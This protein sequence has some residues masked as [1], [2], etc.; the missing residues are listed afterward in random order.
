MKTIT[1]KQQWGSTI[2]PLPDLVNKYIT[3]F[4]ALVLQTISPRAF[5]QSMLADL[6]A[7]DS[8]YI[9][10][11][12]YDVT[13]RVFGSH[14][15]TRHLIGQ[16]G[17]TQPIDYRPNSQ[18]NVGVGFNYNFFGLNLGFKSPFINDDNDIRGKTK[19]FDGQGYIT[20]ASWA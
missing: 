18:Y 20:S 16:E 14:K 5:S 19:P 10:T 12:P 4:L 9:Y 11:Y 6:H 7:A 1:A 13:V 17:N 8:A 15:F 3:A 2:F